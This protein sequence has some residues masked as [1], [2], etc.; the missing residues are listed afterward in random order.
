MVMEVERRH[1][2]FEKKAAADAANQKVQ[3]WETLM[4]N[5]QQALPG[6]LPG[7]KWKIMESVFSL[8]IKPIIAIRMRIDAHQHFWKFDPVRDSWIGDDMQVLKPTF[9]R[10]IYNPFCTKPTLMVA[11][12][13]RPINRK[14]KTGF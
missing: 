13:C 14:K 4:W 12:S 8:R 5:Y 10:N 2:S 7:E 1:F 6:A 11:S 3:E 9:C